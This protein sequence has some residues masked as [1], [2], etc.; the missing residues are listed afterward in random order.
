M[1]KTLLFICT[2]FC[3]TVLLAQTNGDN[4]LTTNVETSMSRAYIRPTI[5][6]IYVTDGSQYANNFAREFSQV[7]P[8]KFNTIEVR[9][10]FYHLSNIPVAKKS[11][12][13]CL[14]AYLQ[15]VFSQEKVSNQIMKGWFPKYDKSIGAY[16]LETLFE[17]GQYAMTD[18]EVIAAKSSSKS[19]ESFATTLGYQLIDRS[20]VVCYLIKEIKNTETKK[21]SV[22]ITPYVYKL[23]F[24]AE[25]SAN[26]DENY[27]TK[28]NGIEECTFPLIPVLDAK[29]SCS[30]SIS[31]NQLDMEKVFDNS[32]VLVNKIADFQAKAT[33]LSTRPVTAKIGKKEGLYVDQRFNVVRLEEEIVKDE[34]GN[35]ST[36]QVAKRRATVRVKKVFD[37][38]TIATGE[39]EGVSKFYKIRGYVIREGY[40]LVENS[41]MGIG[42]SFE[43][44]FA[45]PNVTVDYRLGRYTN[46]SGLLAYAKFGL[47]LDAT[48]QVID[49]GVYVMNTSLGFGK[50]FNLAPFTFT[51]SIGGGK[52]IAL[53]SE[54]DE[55]LDLG[56]FAELNA[57]LGCY[58]TQSSQ[59]YFTLG[60]NL[61]LDYNFFPL[62]A[63]IGLKFE[64]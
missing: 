61:F 49:N 42:V 46:V 41:D 38:R 9:N 50:E 15:Q 3:A 63:G 33:V 54:S 56:Y 14:H 22:N 27:S 40:T 35:I 32:L 24:G 58:L 20:Y 17:K 43:L 52:V 30:A 11:Q 19:L 31:E 34:K 5:T 13:S 28:Q 45:H 51:P 62:N 23:D 10:K 29:K 55:E 47:N 48:S 44:S 8:S 60:Y 53:A 26:F 2:M 39:T 18:E 57:K 4:G 36:Q 21:S 37:N 16:S 25:V 1:K 64:L 7:Q 12:D 59:L 6:R